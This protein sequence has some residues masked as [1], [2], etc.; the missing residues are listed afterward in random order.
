MTENE[1]RLNQG[2]KIAQFNEIKWY[3]KTHNKIDYENMLDLLKQLNFI[4]SYGNI[5]LQKKYEEW[6]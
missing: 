5:E 1:L 3:A 2:L 6:R 4:N